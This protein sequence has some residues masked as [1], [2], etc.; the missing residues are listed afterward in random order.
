MYLFSLAL[1]CS[2]CSIGLNL[3]EVDDI[4]CMMI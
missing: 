4:F 2:D 3:N 1:I